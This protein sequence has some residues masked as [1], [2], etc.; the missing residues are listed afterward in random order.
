MRSR[1]LRTRVA[2][3]ADATLRAEL[4][5]SDGG[6]VRRVRI[7]AC[8]GTTIGQAIEAACRDG[9]IDARL[10]ADRAVAVFGRRR[11]PSERLREGDRIEL[12]GALRVDPKLARQRRVAH[13]RATQGSDR[14]RGG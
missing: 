7:E 10:L 8:A 3:V 5:W 13:R 2:R 14:W 1:R 11:A 9:L 4:A 12:V 6:A